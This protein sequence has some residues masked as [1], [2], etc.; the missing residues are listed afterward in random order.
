MHKLHYS[1]N[2]AKERTTKQDK[3]QCP[4]RC[5]RCWR[6]PFSCALARRRRSS[7]TAYK[8]RQRTPTVSGNSVGWIFWQ[9]W[10][11]KNGPLPL[12][13]RPCAWTP[14]PART[15]TARAPLRS[16]VSR[17]RLCR[18]PSKLFFCGPPHCPRA[19][20]FTCL[21]ASHKLLVAFSRS[22]RRFNHW[23]WRGLP[24]ER[25]RPQAVRG[26]GQKSLPGLYRKYSGQ[27][28]LSLPPL[29]R[30]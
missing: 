30:N 22:M 26:R 16:P 1:T 25:Y 6:A 21:F 13:P 17:T 18:P 24:A 10:N 11:I 5:A 27:R 3:D 23:H 20:I 12:H 15:W 14:A 29:L 9:K 2:T 19:N 28:C 8:G 4:K 7:S